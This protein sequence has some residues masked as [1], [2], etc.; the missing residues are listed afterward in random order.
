M[1]DS[2]E[3][4]CPTAILTSYCRTFTD[5]PYEREIYEW[6]S[7]NYCEN[8]KLNKMLSPEFEARYKLI[9][10]ILNDN[11]NIK[12]VL[13]LAA[14]YSSRG[15]IYSKQDYKYVEMDLDVVAK[16]KIELLNDIDDI[17]S[18]LH[19]ESGNALSKCEKYFNPNQEI[20]IINEGLLRYLTFEEK[21]V[22]ATNIYNFLKKYNGVWITSDVTP[23]KFIQE[24]DKCIPSFNKDLNEVTSRN[25]LNDRFNDIEHINS[26]MRE[27]GFENIETYKFI[28]MKN[29]LKSLEVLGI[30]NSKYDELLESAIVAVISI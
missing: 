2:F 23:K 3:S 21:R 16:N 24:Q 13:E 25:E 30:N 14:G 1:L 29:E 4:I 20:A 5:I 9:N 10:K 11:R 26:F 17:P 12:Q 22:V 19:I 7:A 8:I 18:N 6:L 28:E 15:V 27:I